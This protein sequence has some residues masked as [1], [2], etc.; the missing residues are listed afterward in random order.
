MQ[1]QRVGALHLI[2]GCMYSGKTDELLRHIRVRRL[3][4]KRV[5]LVK[6]AKDTRYR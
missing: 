4:G 3:S 5:L 6:Y 2:V 1:Q